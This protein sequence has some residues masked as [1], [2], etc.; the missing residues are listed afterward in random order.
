MLPA[1]PQLRP[2]LR[3]RLPTAQQKAAHKKKPSGATS[4]RVAAAT[5][6]R[7]RDQS[8]R[9]RSQSRRRRSPR[10]RSHSGR[11]EQQRDNASKRCRRAASRSRARK[12]SNS[13][14]RV[15]QR[16][17]GDTPSPQR[18]GLHQFPGEGRVLPA[19]AEGRRPLPVTAATASATRSSTSAHGARPRTGAQA[20]GDAQSHSP[21]VR[22]M[23][24]M[25][26]DSFP[27]G[28]YQY[29]GV[30]FSQLM[31]KAVAQV[32][33]RGLLVP[34]VGAVFS[35]SLSGASCL[36]ADHTTPLASDPTSPSTRVIIYLH[37]NMPPYSPAGRLR[38][39]TDMEDDDVLLQF[40]TGPAQLELTWF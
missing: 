40:P 32:R 14:S 36:Y 21:P 29:V 16:R 20:S 12:R 5:P 7:R 15:I 19:G 34:S 39:A 25:S 6:K 26:L 17:R 10:R 33:V 1:I 4:V 9:P 35:R 37:G 11:R 2:A 13:R 27:P 18:G 30:T 28:T 3:R 8:T 23:A 38:F 24:Q 31:G 22:Q